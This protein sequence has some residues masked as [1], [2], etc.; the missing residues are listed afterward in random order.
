[1]PCI[2]PPF[3]KNSYSVDALS[4][5]SMQVIDNR[6]YREGRQAQLFRQY[7]IAQ[8][9]SAVRDEFLIIFP[10]NA[11][12]IRTPASPYSFENVLR[13]RKIRML[14]RAPR[15]AVIR[16]IRKTKISLVDNNHRI[17]TFLQRSFTSF[18]GKEF[19][20]GLLGDASSTIRGF[21]LRTSETISSIS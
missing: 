19:P 5:L 14:K 15:H 4:P 7:I 2:F 20:V 8:I 9:A 6:L 18:G 12:P 16:G 3:L 1:M 10:T 11:W 13:Y 17:S 21:M